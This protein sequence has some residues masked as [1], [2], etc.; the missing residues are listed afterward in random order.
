MRNINF[1]LAKLTHDLLSD[2]N[3]FMIEPVLIKEFKKAIIVLNE[4]WEIYET[5]FKENI[6]FV[7]SIDEQMIFTILASKLKIEFL[8]KD[9]EYCGELITTLSQFQKSPLNLADYA[10]IVLDEPLYTAIINTVAI[11]NIFYYQEFFQIIYQDLY[12]PDMDIETKNYFLRSLYKVQNKTY[13]ILANDNNNL[14]EIYNIFYRTMIKCN[15]NKYVFSNKDFRDLKT[16]LIILYGNN[17][18]LKENLKEQII[19]IENKYNSPEAII[20]SV[21]RTLNNLKQNKKENV[22][23]LYHD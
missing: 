19:D 17:E 20:K 9:P 6:K 10:K 14:F 22:R 4:N 12:T 18:N 13:N 16:I 5:K 3:I 1:Y 23:R 2:E 11:S 21:L 15:Q 7:F 8:N